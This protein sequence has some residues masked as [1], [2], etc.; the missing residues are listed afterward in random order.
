MLLYAYDLKE[1]K[2]TIIYFLAYWVQE[3]ELRG[4][5]VTGISQEIRRQDQKD[6][7]G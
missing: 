4:H 5:M 3:Y 1:L 7:F 6:T 2:H